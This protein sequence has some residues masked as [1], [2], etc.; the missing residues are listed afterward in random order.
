MRR[1]IHI[2]TKFLIGFLHT[3]RNSA[4]G[5]FFASSFTSSFIWRHGSAQGA[6]KLVIE[7]RFRSADKSSLNSS[8]D[9]TS[10]KFGV[11]MINY[12][13]VDWG[14][15]SSEKRLLQVIEIFISNSDVIRAT[16][17]TLGS[18]VRE[19]LAGPSARRRARYIMIM[20]CFQLTFLKHP[21]SLNHC[22]R[23]KTQTS[24]LLVVTL[25]R[26][27]SR[28]WAYWTSSHWQARNI[29]WN[30]LYGTAFYSPYFYFLISNR[31]Y[32]RPSHTDC[33]Q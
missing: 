14:V 19:Q 18:R 8:G 33:P 24:F 7:I 6:Q 5:Y 11:D 12:C 31:R 20:Y 3:W 4:A 29:T 22:H 26:L 21:R 32:S 28:P 25:S 9:F 27:Q 30:A 2:S 10:K 15:R 17:P 16:G 13:I 1:T 23:A